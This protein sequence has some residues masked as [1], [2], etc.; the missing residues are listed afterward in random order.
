[1][2]VRMYVH[3]HSSLPLLSLVLL[4]LC[5]PA[6]PDYFLDFGFVVYGNVLRRSMFLANTGHFPINISVNKKALVGSGFSVDATDKIKALPEGERVNFTVTFD[7]ASI[8]CP[9]QEIMANLPFKVI[10]STHICTC[11]N[12]L[13]SFHID[14]HLCTCVR[15]MYMSFILDCQWS[16][17]HPQTS[18][19]CHPTRYRGVLLSCRLWCC[20]VWS[21]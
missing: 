13:Y 19:R 18:R 3:M 1:M 14:I 2:Y 9:K 7:P 12:L 17:L 10:Y 5:R 11:M 4:S 21:V 16:L 20:V 15:V 6:I 8:N